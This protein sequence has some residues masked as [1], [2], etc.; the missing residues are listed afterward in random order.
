MANTTIVVMPDFNIPEKKKDENWHKQAVQALASDAFQDDY[1]FG[2]TVMDVNYHYYQNGNNSDQYKYLQE[3]ED[4]TPYPARWLHLDRIRTKIN[5]VAGELVKRGYEIKVEAINEEAKA[6]RLQLR[7]EMRVDMHMKP[8]AK[9]LESQYGIPLMPGDKEIPDTPEELED[10]VANYKEMSET[11]MEFALRFM[12][13]KYNWEYERLAALRDVLITGRGF[14]RVDIV[15]GVPKPKRVDP[16]FIVFDRYATDDFLSDSTYFGE[17]EYLPVAEA[18]VRYNLSEKE[19]KAAYKSAEAIRNS[20]YRSTTTDDSAFVSLLTN[21][22][23]DFFDTSS[24]K[25]R[26]L[27]L[28]AVWK[29]TKVNKYKEV[30]NN[31]GAVD[32]KRDSGRSKNK[33]KEIVQ[34]IDIWRRGTLVAG[35]FMKDWGEMENRPTSVDSLAETLPPYVAC[36][37]NYIDFQTVSI[38]DQLRDLQDLKDMA[39]YSV[40]QEMAASGGKAFVYDISQAPDGW[41]PED[42]AKYVK[43]SR[44]AFI[45]SSRNPGTSFNQFGQVDLSM[46]AN[47]KNYLEISMAIDSEM[48]AITGINEARQGLVQGASQAVGVTQSAL[49]QSTLATETLVRIFEMAATKVLDLSARYIKLLW[50]EEKERYAPIIGESGVNFLEQDIE[51]DL[52]DYAVFVESLPKLF[53]DESTYQQLLQFGIQSGNLDIIEAFEL[54]LEKNPREGLLKLKR[55]R[56]RKQREAQAAAQAQQAQQD[57]AAQQQEK[58]KS[59]AAEEANQGANFRQVAGDQAKKEIAMSKIKSDLLTTALNKK[60]NENT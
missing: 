11:V 12:A 59:A 45:D 52:Q 30:T 41:A 60:Q 40:Q 51:L 7:N 19:L 17:V 56:D 6:R 33:G 32:I 5:T 24:G 29:D 35:K 2:R 10:L 13:K 50:P 16:R 3:A 55:F 37:P 47:L 27:V 28:K 26:V 48:N 36:L 14:W 25:L 43:V 44:I 22:T 42:I 53:Q 23:V 31:Y 54:S 4:G 1:S 49:Y 20:T 34:H 57:Q 15:N 46:S 9:E 58:I 8:I 39:W 21:S 18:A 38:V